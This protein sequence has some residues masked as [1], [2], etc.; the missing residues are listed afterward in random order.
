MKQSASLIDFD[1]LKSNEIR[2]LFAAKDTA[3]GL[4]I[5][6]DSRV[7]TNLQI[8]NLFSFWVRTTFYVKVTFSF[9]YILILPSDRLKCSSNNSLV[10]KS[11]FDDGKTPMILDS[12]SLIL[13]VC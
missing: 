8:S 3:V 13:A 11:V 4:I 2:A 10:L 6:L 12:V 7:L 1:L 9:Y 5:K